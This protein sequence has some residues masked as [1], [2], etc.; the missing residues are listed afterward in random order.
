MTHG[1]FFLHSTVQLF[2]R[3]GRTPATPQKKSIQG[4]KLYV[5]QKN[6]FSSVI[7]KF[8]TFYGLGTKNIY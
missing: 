6:L 4:Q 5:V 2:F 7:G 1:P 8:V 3:V